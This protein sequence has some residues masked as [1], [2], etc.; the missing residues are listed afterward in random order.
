MALPPKWY[1]FLVG[2][3]ASLGSFL[4]GYD[5][6]V[7]AEVVQCQTF[8]AKFGN[9]PSQIGAVVSLFTGGAFFGA[10]F[11]GYMSDYFG[12]RKTI[13]AATVVFLLGACLQTAAQSLSYLW[14]GRFIT[15]MGVGILA[16]VVP[17][18][19]AELAHPSIRGR[20]TA[21]QQFMLGIGSLLASWASYGTYI[22]LTDSG[23]WRI[24]LGIQMAPAIVLGTCIFFMPES[25]R[26]LIDHGKI[27]QGFAVLAQLH[28]NGDEMDPFV[29]AEFEA[30]QT[31]ITHEHDHAAKRWVE[32]VK[33]KINFKRVFIAVSVQGSIQMTGVSFI[34]YYAPSIF[35]QIGIS[36]STTLLLQAI[37]SIIALIAQA[38]CI[39]LIDYL[40]RRWVLIYGNLV[41]MVAWI[42]VTALV[43][44]YGNV[45]NATG[46][47]WAFIV[48]TWLYQF[49][50]SFACGPLS[51]IIPA[52]VFNTAT[53]AKG[54]AI[55]SMTSFATNTLIGQVSPIALDNVGWRYFLFFVICNF[56][57]AIF[58]YCLLPETS[59]VPLENMDKLFDSSWWVP[60]WSQEH[61]DSLRKELEERTEEIKEKDSGAAEHIDNAKLE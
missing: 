55:A 56:T 10:F 38:L 9:D 40:G 16:M 30:I 59:K 12:R 57:N 60:G 29:R 34:Q 24:P 11:A 2:V 31:S 61:I 28:S 7:I 4:F 13:S 41:N 51:W 23:Q 8:I 50:F 26:W 53:R 32:L 49:S 43:A 17:L 54:V 48:M 19:Q 58:F 35:A 45:T 20:V 47:H 1:Q 27:E 21:L 5:L 25:P 15:G 14:S 44:I 37:N 42:I 33:D 52:E 39:L 6:G 18:Y 46:A 36:T 22:H 3:F